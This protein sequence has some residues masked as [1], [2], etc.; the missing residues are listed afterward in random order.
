MKNTIRIFLF[1]VLINT[2]AFAH[3][4]WIETNPKGEIQVSQEIRVYF[5]EFSAGVREKTDGEVFQNA[6][7][8]T[9]WVTNQK[10]DKIKLIPQVKDVSKRR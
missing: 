2:Q 9:L 5:G 3:F 1:S 4:F 10:G 6:K 7:D 8:F